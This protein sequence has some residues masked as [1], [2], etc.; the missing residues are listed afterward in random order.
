MQV[1]KPSRLASYTVL[2]ANGM[3]SISACVIMYR[4]LL[5]NTNV[6]TESYGAGICISVAPCEVLK[7]E[8]KGEWQLQIRE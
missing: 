8:A 1:S 6:N 2:A 3:Q 5:Q 4:L 7:I